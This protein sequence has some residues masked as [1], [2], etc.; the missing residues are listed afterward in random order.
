MRVLVLT[1]I[2]LVSLSSNSFAMNNESLYKW[3]KPYADR[4]FKMEV[5]NDLGCLAYITGA[6]DYADLV[7]F[8]MNLQV[9]KE[10]REIFI[11]SYFGATVDANNKNVDA[12]IQAYLNKMKN[13]PE[14]WQYSPKESLRE[15][16]TELMPCE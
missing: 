1:L 16:F 10:P 12:L 2:L 7:C 11:Q 6:A 8:T 14:K 15:I 3:C 4:A 9:K 13:E 5:N